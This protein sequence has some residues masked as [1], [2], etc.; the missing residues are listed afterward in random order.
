[1]RRLFTPASMRTM[2]FVILFAALLLEGTCLLADSY[3]DLL[4]SA[5]ADTSN[6]KYDVAIGKYQAALK[7]HPGAPEVLNNLAVVYYQVKRYAEAYAAVAGI[8]SSHKE[9]KSAALIAGLSAV[10]CNRPQDAIAPLERLLEAEPSNRDALLGL[11][12]AEFALQDYSKA[13]EVYHRETTQAPKDSLA[14]YGLAVCQERRAEDASKR[15]SLMAGGSAYSKQLLGEYLQ[16][17]GDKKLAD[18]AFGQSLTTKD[19]ASPEAEELYKRARELAS[20]SRQAFETFVSLAPDSWQAEVFFGDVARQHGELLPAL[21]HYQ[22]AAQQHPDTAAPD[23]GIGT[24]YWEMGDFDKATTYLHETLR[25]N[26]HAMQAVFELAN[27]AVRRHAD[28]EAIPL[29]SRYLKSQP[30]ALAAHADLGR[31]YFHLAQ[32]ESAVKELQMGSGADEQGDVHYQ[33]SIALRKLGRIQEAAE[34]LATS[35]SIRKENASRDQRLQ[36]IH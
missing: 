5:A 35:T 28:A 36:S 27:I 29:L 32:Y 2:R 11:A 21:E 7:L 23:L 19:Q 34:A 6:G 20:E 4:Q 15:L 8:W 18:E 17:S 14:W 16:T 30:G 33:L 24:V 31:A 26:P 22:R 10:Q 9:L 1:M 3:S 12:S 25:R 13:A